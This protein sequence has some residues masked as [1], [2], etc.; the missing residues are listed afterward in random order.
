L[1]I[2]EYPSGS[3]PAPAIWNG[4]AEADS[5]NAAQRPSA[6]QS[7]PAQLEKKFAEENRRSFEAGLQRGHE[8]CRNTERM[9]QSAARSQENALRMEQSTR[10]IQSFTNAREHYLRQVEQEV[11][12]LAL[13]IAARILRR[14]AQMDPLLLTGAVR[15]ALGQLSNS[16][17]VRLRVPATEQ[18]LWR[19]TIAHIPNLGV[20]P[21]VEADEDMRL[22][23][24]IVET[25][26]GSV[27]LSTRAQ[28]G[29]I[30]R[31]F[32]DRAQHVVGGETIPASGE[33]AARP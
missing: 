33:L 30:E 10:L 16:T 13:A 3:E 28:L 31:G 9:A 32:L 22:G 6:T 19:E 5:A 29:E 8:E 18:Q 27:D 15:A 24:C 21:S 12:S 4:F 17:E 23:D 1:E 26:L 25:S 11:V 20:R 7:I 14:E 2:F